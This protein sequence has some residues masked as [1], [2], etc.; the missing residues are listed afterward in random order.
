MT[1][2]FESPRRT[3]SEIDQELNRVAKRLS[4]LIKALVSF[5]EDREDIDSD[6]NANEAMQLLMELKE[7]GILEP[8][9]GAK[10]P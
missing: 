1:E 6:G 2:R 4:T 3:I 10:L 7:L 5:L 8:E 9:P